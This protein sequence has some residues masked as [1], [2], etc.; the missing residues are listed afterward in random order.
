MFETPDCNPCERFHERVL[1]DTQIR[2]LL[3]NFDAV[4]LDS[5]DSTRKITTPDGKS[6]SPLKWAEELQLE[7]DISVVF[8]DEEG[9]EVHRIDSEAGK[10]RVAG[11][12]Q[13]VLE[14]AYHRHEQ[15]LRWR[16]ENAIRQKQGN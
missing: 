8:F 11:S 13:Y 6:F 14:K 5:S 2:K 16:R 4:Q 1:S 10:D 15:F 12:M 7:Y 9:N 3:S